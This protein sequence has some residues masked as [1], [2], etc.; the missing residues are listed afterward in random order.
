VRA[1]L[2]TLLAARGDDAQ[3]FAEAVKEARAIPAKE[4]TRVEAL[5]VVGG[6][7]ARV[8]GPQGR[9]LLDEA[10]AIIP[11]LPAGG[12]RDQAALGLVRGLCIANLPDGSDRARARV[13]AEGVATLQTRAEAEEAIALAARAAG[14]A[15][16]LARLRALPSERDRRLAFADLAE[17]P[18]VTGNRPLLLSMIAECVGETG[19]VCRALTSLVIHHATRAERLA[20]ARL[21]G[22]PGIGQTPTVEDVPTCMRPAAQEL[23]ARHASGGV[24]QAEFAAQ[25]Q[26]LRCG[27]CVDRPVVER[28]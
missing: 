3:A 18:T 21:V 20:L 23:L 14:E 28:R 9:Q 17:H 27:R 2:L 4:P 12:P 13:I 11:R 24:T 1:R 26:A 19:A 15:D 8:D 6:H 16:W 10:E 25:W 7:L 22:P 5:A